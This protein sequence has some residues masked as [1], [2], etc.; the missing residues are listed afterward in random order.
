M[1]EFSSNYLKQRISKQYH[2]GCLRFQTTIIV[3]DKTTNKHQRW[4]LSKYSLTTEHH[5]CVTCEIKYS[6]TNSLFENYY[7][8]RGIKK[9]T[10]I[11]LRSALQKELVPKTQKLRTVKSLLCL[12]CNLG[13]CITVALNQAY[14]ISRKPQYML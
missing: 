8:C 3:C 4:S 5:L 13:L 6:K 10:I 11:I 1:F 7:Q 2:K 14:I 12:N 9:I